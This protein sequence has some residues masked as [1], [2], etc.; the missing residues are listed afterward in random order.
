M[1]LIKDFL[2]MEEFLWEKFQIN[3]ITI[4]PVIENFDGVISFNDFVT[5]L[6]NLAANK[7]VC[8]AFL[9]KTS[10]K[11]INERPFSLNPLRSFYNEHKSRLT[12]GLWKPYTSKIFL[13]L[14]EIPE[15][16]R[17]EIIL[18]HYKS[19]TPLQKAEPYKA[20]ADD[21]TSINYKDC[22]IKVCSRVEDMYILD[23]FKNHKI[24]KELRLLGGKY[25]ISSALFRNEQ[26]MG[27]AKDFI[28]RN[29]LEVNDYL[30]IHDFIIN[31][32][33]WDHSDVIYKMLW[34]KVGAKEGYRKFKELHRIVVLIALDEID[35]RNSMG[36]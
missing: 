4:L 31:R 7:E 36:V 29:L 10:M 24:I 8:E 5:N 21:K 16:L 20:D 28:D 35:E 14:K 30:K 17:R 27:I 25:A 19:D 12:S 32:G 34:S 2:M 15:E 13:R 18:N 3:V 23:N 6:Y 11:I 26:I 9:N 22:F 1:R 33:E